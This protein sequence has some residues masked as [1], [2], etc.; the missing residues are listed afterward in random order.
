MNKSLKSGLY[1]VTAVAVI[2]AAIAIGGR[3]WQDS[4]VANE[5][6]PSSETATESATGDAHRASNSTETATTPDL[7]KPQSLSVSELMDRDINPAMA[8]WAYRF[9][10]DPEDPEFF[11]EF[12]LLRNTDGIAFEQCFDVF[13]SDGRVE[14]ACEEF[15][16]HE[17][18]EYDMDLLSQLALSDPAAAQVLGYRYLQREPSR[19]EDYFLRAVALSGK[20]GPIVDYL[21]TRQ[22]LV[23]DPATGELLDSAATL[24]GL[25]LATVVDRIG[26]PL[27]LANSYKEILER[28]GVSKEEIEKAEAGSDDVIEHMERTRTSSVGD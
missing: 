21:S 2:I 9:L 23:L 25:T 14:Q 12:F 24:H 1:L 7:T 16:V 20:P 15:G 27:I 28:Y 11:E 18:F 3:F 6:V 13:L 4:D 22:D 19:A 8:D 26:Y 10:A 17:F 5:P